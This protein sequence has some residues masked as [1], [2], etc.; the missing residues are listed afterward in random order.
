MFVLNEVLIRYYSSNSV[1][2]I[3]VLQVEE[4]FMLTGIRM[5]RLL[6]SPYHLEKGENNMTVSC[7][8]SSM[9][10]IF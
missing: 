10:Y 3:S 9:L 8:T 6:F 4:E 2:F 1:K 5:R 7:I